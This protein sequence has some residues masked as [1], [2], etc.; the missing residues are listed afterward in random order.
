MDLLRQPILVRCGSVNGRPTYKDYGM[1]YAEVVDSNGLILKA[2]YMPSGF[3]EYDNILR[4]DESANPGEYAGYVTPQIR[5]NPDV[6]LE[7]TGGYP[8]HY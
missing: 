1:Q 4:G 5:D 7:A 3:R 6:G 8:G 2:G